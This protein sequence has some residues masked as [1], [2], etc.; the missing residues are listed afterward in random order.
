MHLKG[1][2]VFFSN[3]QKCRKAPLGVIYT[4]FQI[5]KEMPSSSSFQFLLNNGTLVTKML[6]LWLAKKSE[7]SHEMENF[8][9]WP[10]ILK[11]KSFDWK[12][13]YKLKYEDWRSSNRKQ[14]KILY[15]WGSCHTKHYIP[16]SFNAAMKPFRRFETPIYR[17]KSGEF[18]K[19][20]SMNLA[21]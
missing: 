4:F 16:Q 20:K 5:K 12:S 10:G 19:K 6:C 14:K 7:L 9:I 11:A 3:E 13:I 1:F 15:V 21:I 2:M 18:Y 8:K 17:T